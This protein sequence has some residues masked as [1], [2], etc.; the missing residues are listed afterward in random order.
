MPTLPGSESLFR[1]FGRGSYLSLGGFAV[2]MVVAFMIMAGG[3]N[4]ADEHGEGDAQEHGG[5]QLEA[6]VGMELKFGEEVAAGDANEGASGE[7]QS[8]A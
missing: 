3:F 4:L 1:I 2:I 5:G 7:G 8:R 6:V